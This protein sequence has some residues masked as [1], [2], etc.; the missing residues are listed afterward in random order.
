ML[1]KNFLN[2]SSKEIT[3]YQSATQSLNV[4]LQQENNALRQL[5]KQYEALLVQ[6][7]TASVL[8]LNKNDFKDKQKLNTGTKSG[9][10]IISIA[11]WNSQTV[12]IKEI[13]AAEMKLFE[14]E[15]EILSKLKHPNWF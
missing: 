10:S 2:F 3:D 12:V 11:K 8:S 1:P 4:A 13:D 9:S 14:K 5:I 15:V 6:Q 7:K